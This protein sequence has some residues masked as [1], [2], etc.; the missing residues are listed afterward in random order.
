MHAAGTVA[1]F[2]IVLRREIIRLGYASDSRQE[3]GGP[4]GSDYNQPAKKE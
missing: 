3:M 1:H 4:V 2:E